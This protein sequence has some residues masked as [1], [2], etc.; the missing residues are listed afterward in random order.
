MTTPSGQ[1]AP[2][3]QVPLTEPFRG[4]TFG[5][6]VGR[7]WRNYANFQG[8]ASLSEYWWAY[9]FHIILI[10]VPL[11]N[12]AMII[13]GIAVAVRRL[14]DTNRSGWFYL[15]AL[16][17]LVGWIILIVL[18]TGPAVAAGSRFD[19]P[20]GGAVPQPAVPQ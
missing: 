14:H 17:P 5:E 4:A 13:P 7:Y 12:L 20:R 10:W 1:Y 18:L 11:L 6:A 9:L 19:G 2:R 15:L 3:P 8:R 16:I